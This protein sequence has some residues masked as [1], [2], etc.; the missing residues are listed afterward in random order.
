MGSLYSSDLGLEKVSLTTYRRLSPTFTAL[1]DNLKTVHTSA[2][3]AAHT[4]LAGK[5]VRKDP[6]DTI[7]PLVRIHPVTGKKCIFVSGEFITHIVGMKD[8]ES[9]LL[10]EFL[11]QHMVTCHDIQARVRWQPRTIVMFDNRSTIRTSLTSLLFDQCIS[12]TTRQILPAWIIATTR[13]A[14]RP[15]TS[16]DYVP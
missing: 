15:D 9:K 5:L 16:F 12:N 3:M 4:R 8:P 6:I 1:L 7:H 11:V 10:L 13:M 14:L 2:K